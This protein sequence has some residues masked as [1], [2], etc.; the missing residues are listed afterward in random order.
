LDPS[1]RR[2]LRTRETRAR[3]KAERQGLRL[4]KSRRRDPDALDYGRYYLVDPEHRMVYSG[5]TL[6]QIEDYLKGGRP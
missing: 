1:E 3:R 4:E 5:V 6:D 2:A